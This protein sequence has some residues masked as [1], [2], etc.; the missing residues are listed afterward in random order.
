MSLHSS[1]LPQ[2]VGPLGPFLRC[3]AWEAQLSRTYYCVLLGSLTPDHIVRESCF[4]CLP[5]L[6][7]SVCI[8][9]LPACSAP[10]IEH[11]RQKEWPTGLSSH[12]FGKIFT[13]NYFEENMFFKCWISPLIKHIYQ[14]KLNRILIFYFIFFPPALGIEPRA[15]NM[16]GKHSPTKSTL[17]FSTFLSKV[18]ISLFYL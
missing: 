13:L 3:S 17:Q 10:R 2:M 11:T 12:Q 7:I 18:L 4:V 14:V 16:L 5:V 8:Y 9:N 1:S 6:L 15:L